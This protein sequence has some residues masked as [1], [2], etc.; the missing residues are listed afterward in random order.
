M[1]LNQETHIKSVDIHQTYWQ[2]TTTHTI[3]SR[4]NAC[5]WQNVLSVCGFP[6]RKGQR[7]RERERVSKRENILQINSSILS[8]SH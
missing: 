7:E 1:T 6:I 2:S 8:F 4:M 3:F 5:Y